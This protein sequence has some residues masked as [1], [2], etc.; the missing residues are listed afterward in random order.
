MENIKEEIKSKNVNNINIINDDVQKDKKKDCL[1]NGILLIFNK[2]TYEY[3]LYIK[4]KK[5]EKNDIKEPIIAEVQPEIVG[6]IEEPNEEPKP[7]EAPNEGNKIEEKEEAEIKEVNE[8]KEESI[9]F[10]KE[11][12]LLLL[13]KELENTTFN[14]LIKTYKEKNVI[15]SV[16]KDYYYY[17]VTR[18]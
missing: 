3:N 9:E 4:W 2:L 17:F 1:Y 16:I 18:N 8:I 15:G 10:V 14:D 7:N 6:V 11:Q 12:S 13:E 5:D